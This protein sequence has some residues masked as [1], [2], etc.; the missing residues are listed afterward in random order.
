MEL[1]I[2]CVCFVVNKLATIIGESPREIRTPLVIGVDD[3]TTV[4]LYRLM[5]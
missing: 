5:K 3:H 2:K 1:A 4:R